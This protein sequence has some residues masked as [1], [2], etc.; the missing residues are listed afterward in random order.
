VPFLK[1]TLFL[2]A[3]HLPLALFSQ[4]V[5]GKPWTV[6]LGI[7]S[8]TFFTKPSS[9]NV[10]YISPRFKWSSYEL[11]EEEEKH[12]DKFMNTR[13]MM[14]L[15]YRPP[16]KVMCAAFNVQSRLLHRKRLT[17]DIYGGVKFFA[18]PGPDF[19]N[20]PYLKNGREIW[21]MSIGLIT[22]LDLG[23]IA[24]FIDLGGDLIITVGTEVKLHAIHKKPKSRYKLRPR[25]VSAQR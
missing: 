24:P 5:I 1:S 21:Y 14:E 17:L 22:Q 10:R 8:N 12:P 23:F 16:F 18:V 4:A 9:I 13:L 7:S 20:I 11:T 19:V 25:R 15:I 2:I 6:E 3:C